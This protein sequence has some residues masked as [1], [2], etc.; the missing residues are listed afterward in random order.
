MNIS[1]YKK[2][3]FLLIISAVESVTI[4]HALE[5]IGVSSAIQKDWKPRGNLIY[6]SES[7]ESITDLNPYYDH[8]HE[9][10]K[11]EK[12]GIL[13]NGSSHSNDTIT[14]E[15]QQKASLG[16]KIVEE[17]KNKT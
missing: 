6:T 13:D 15:I 16:L 10:N 14:A 1:L 2:I 8:G 7:M 5:P 4:M 17:L 3:L 9:K 11:D 12:K